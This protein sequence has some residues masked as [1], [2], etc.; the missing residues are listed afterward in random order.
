MDG[1]SSDIKQAQDYFVM[2]GLPQVLAVTI[3]LREVMDGILLVGGILSR[4][5]AFLFVIEM[6]GAFIVLN[7][8]HGIPIPKGYELALLS[9]SILF[10]VISV[11]L[12]YRSW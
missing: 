8:S 5:V 7:V 9:I 1:H 10:L 12:V 4:I 11:S 3:G 2:I 6:I